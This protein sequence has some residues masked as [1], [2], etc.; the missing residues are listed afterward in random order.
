[1]LPGTGLRRESWVYS[2]GLSAKGMLQQQGR[3]LHY[4][5]ADLSVDDGV[6]CDGQKSSHSQ[7]G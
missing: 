3:L 5:Q 1:M 2:I 4:R 7:V 6:L